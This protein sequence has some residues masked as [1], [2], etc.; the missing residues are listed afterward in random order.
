MH[1]FTILRNGHF[2][3][4]PFII[5]PLRQRITQV[6]RR[7]A[8]PPVIREIVYTGHF[9]ICVCNHQVGNVGKV[10]AITFLSFEVHLDITWL[11][12]LDFHIA[13]NGRFIVIEPDILFLTVAYHAHRGV[14][15]ALKR[16]SNDLRLVDMKV[17]ADSGLGTTPVFHAVIRYTDLIGTLGNISIP[18]KG[19]GLH[20]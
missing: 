6:Y 14:P 13:G 3:I 16:Q 10:P 18:C 8:A 9:A 2:V 4:E 12:D 1:H 7:A 19:Y 5:I 17:C 15:L 20:P 11:T